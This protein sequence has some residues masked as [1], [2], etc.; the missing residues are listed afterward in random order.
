MDLLTIK[1]V[2]VVEG[3]L[4]HLHPTY[5]A[6]GLLTLKVIVMGEWGGSLEGL[7]YKSKLC[8]IDLL[9]FLAVLVL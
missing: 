2:A 6:I 8:V 4:L 1:G 3:G 5:D 7:L 9:T